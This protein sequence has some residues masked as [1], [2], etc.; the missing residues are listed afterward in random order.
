MGKYYAVKIGRVPG[1]YRTWPE[2][3]KQ[4]HGF[5]GAAFKSFECEQEARNFLLLDSSEEKESS[6]QEVESSPQEIEPS[7][8]L[9]HTVSTSLEKKD[10][11]RISPRKSLVSSS[12]ETSSTKETPLKET[13]LEETS[14]KE[15]TLVNLVSESLSHP[16]NLLEIYTDASHQRAKTYLGIGAYCKYKGLEY[17]MSYECDAKLLA[18]YN[19]YDEECSNPTAEFIAFAEVLKYFQGANLKPNTKIVFYIDY[20]GVKNWIEGTWTAKASYIQNVRNIALMRMDNIG[21]PIKIL[22]VKGHTGVVGNEKADKLAGNLEN[23][24]NFDKL[25]LASTR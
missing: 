24:S 11:I 3:Q 22:H 9:M 6:L 7:I 20:I 5:S 2:C 15:K 12:K 21:C 25:V 13:S 17:S 14:F 4:T 10:K 1:I 19:I 23:F 8:G 18:T 16:E